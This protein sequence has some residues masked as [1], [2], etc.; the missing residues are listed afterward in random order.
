MVVPF[1]EPPIK[2]SWIDC[3]ANETIELD[4]SAMEAYVASMH[5]RCQA[6][7]QHSL[8][9]LPMQYN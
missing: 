5:I 9:N 8:T 2:A 3:I 1:A 6:I 7:A 4:F